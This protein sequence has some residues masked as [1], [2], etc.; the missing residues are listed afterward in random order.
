MKLW[1]K[2]T[3]V[4]QLIESFTVGQ[5]RNLD[6]YLAPH[7]CLASIAHVKMLAQIQ[8]VSNSES[9]AIV[10]ALQDLYHQAVAGELIIEPACEDIHSQI[11]LN[12][13]RLLGDQGKKVHS[14]RSRNDQV[15]VA[16]KLYFRQELESLVLQSNT[17]FDTL[18]SLA[19][20]HQ[21]VLMPGYTH[22]QVAMVSSF[23]LWFSAF[24]ESLADDMRLVQAAF[25][26]AN[27]NPLGSAAGYGSSFPLDRHYTTQVLGFQ[28]LHY[29]VI[30]AQLSRGKTELS[31]SYAIAGIASTLNKL[32]MDICLY[33]GQDFGFI[34]FP[35][36]LTTG[37][38]IMPHKKNPDVWELIRGQAGRLM[39]LPGEL[40]MMIHNLPAGYHR[41]FQLLKE[42]I[43]PR[44]HDLHSILRLADYMLREIRIQ[45]NLI[46]Q[47]KYHYLFSVERVNELVLQGIP[48][49]DA[50]RQVGR[51]IE[52]GQF[53][54]N[55]AIRHTHAGS[56]GNLCLPEIRQ[57]MEAQLYAFDFETIH[58]K[59]EELL[60][61]R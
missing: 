51:E 14:G 46:H 19:D 24:A 9:A 48:F 34:S 33:N 35:D 61:E 23:G 8:L 56:L 15:L 44:I 4:D 53:K 54:P 16:L 27:L 1:Q 59:I 52:S 17:L 6:L 38:S 42:I 32:A 50:Y 12:L 7:D 40:T 30:N 22:M 13:T 41:E 37:S 39:A 60:Q 43:I 11:E 21:A 47:E 3:S 45:E 49:R 31:I 2:N 58:Q 20:K 55:Y 10:K 18:L 26:M 28:D 36:H 29:N 57:K 25:Q 5:D